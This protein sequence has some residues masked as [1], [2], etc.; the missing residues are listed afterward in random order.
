[1]AGQ[2]PTHCYGLCVCASVDA[3]S[4]KRR[5]TTKAS[6]EMLIRRRL[7]TLVETVREYDLTVDVALVQSCRNRLT[8]VP[9]RWL[10]LTKEGGELALANCAAVGGRLGPDQVAK[11]HCQSGHPG[12]NQTLYFA[13]LVDPHVSKK[14]VRSIVRAC[15]TCWSINPAHV[16]WK[17]G[18]LSVESNWIRL[19]M[20]IVHHNGEHFLTLIDCG[21][22]R[23]AVWQPLCRRDATTV[24]RQLESVFL[25]HG[26][27]TEILA[28]NGTAFTSEQFRKFAELGRTS[29]VCLHAKRKQDHRVE[30]QDCQHH[31]S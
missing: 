2:D 18:K 30:P 26:P 9:H 20:D 23:F 15:E 19:A 1:M 16:R 25:E 8:R 5:L 31:R 10:D 24:I 13:G 22:S 27:P 11:V 3:L 7:A 29:S 6:S 12:V 4:G 28:D 21:P 14:D 17:K